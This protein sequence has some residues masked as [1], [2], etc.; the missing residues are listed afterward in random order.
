VLSDV[1]EEDR[2]AEV[3]LEKNK[4]P[5]TK[6]LGLSWTARD[7]K[8]LFYYS[9]PAEDVQYTKRNVLKKTA[10]LFDPL[11]FLSPFVVK[12]KLF[13]QQTWLQALEWDD[14]LPPEHKEQWKSWFSELPLLEE[15]KIPR[16]SKDRNREVHSVTLHTF[17]DA[18]EKAYS[19]AVYSRHEYQDGTITTRLV[20]S[21]TRLAPVKAVSLGLSSW[22]LQSD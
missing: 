16:C 12:A 17:S 4:L 13:M 15:V 5:V 21:K 7:D 14:V 18:S 10:T 8:F 20:A 9:P 2:A 11:G 22:G 19:A 3:D 1:P 6:T